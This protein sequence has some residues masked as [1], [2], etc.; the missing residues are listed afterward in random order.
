MRKQ[1]AHFRYIYDVHTKVKGKAK[2]KG[3]GKEGAKLST[4]Q[5]ANQELNRYP[6]QDDL[7]D[8][9]SV[10]F[11]CL[12]RMAQEDPRAWA[13]VAASQPVKGKGKGKGADSKGKGKRKPANTS[14]SSHAPPSNDPRSEQTWNTSSRP[15][16]TQHS[17]SWKDSGNTGWKSRSWN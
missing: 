16:D 17:G 9:F 11:K 5:Q 4:A 13:H 8:F 14:S 7:F 12:T 15:A 6:K 3:T 1:G 10:Q 2:G